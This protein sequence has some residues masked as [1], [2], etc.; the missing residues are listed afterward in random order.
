MTQQNNNERSGQERLL[1]LVLAVIALSVPLW[2]E[3]AAQPGTYVFTWRWT[4]QQVLVESIVSVVHLLLVIA[5]VFM[6]KRAV[7]DMPQWPMVR[8]GA[9]IW[10][11]LVALFAAFSVL[12]FNIGENQVIESYED[13]GYRINFVRMS[14]SAEAQT[15]IYSVLSCNHTLLYKNILYMDRLVGADE[16][17]VTVDSDEIMT[18][19]YSFQGRELREQRYDLAA[20][21]QQ[22]RAGEQ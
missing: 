4:D 5:G 8:I 2:Y 21:Y 9:W 17:S 10:V 6:L 19:A 22:C 18:A 3:I 16:V 12:M 15:Q 1:W 11:A 13:D 7:G 14:G 20:F